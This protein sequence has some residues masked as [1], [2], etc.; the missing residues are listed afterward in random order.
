MRTGGL[1]P[2]RKAG[3]STRDRRSKYVLSILKNGKTDMSNSVS[4]SGPDGHETFQL[5]SGSAWS[6]FCTWIRGI[7]YPRSKG[8]PHRH[9]LD[10][11]DNGKVKDTLAV[12]NELGEALDEHGND[13]DSDTADV[14][15]KLYSLIGIGNSDEEI[16][17]T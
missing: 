7:G 11:V 15:E 12:S 13:L 17:V 1:R 4:F 16:T 2:K 6:H 8:P 3:T 14:A 9:L 5:A 10:L